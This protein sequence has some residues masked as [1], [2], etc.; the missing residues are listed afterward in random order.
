MD[1]SSAR[2][3]LSLRPAT[4]LA[5]LLAPVF[6]ACASA[7][8]AAPEPASHLGDVTA[9]GWEPADLDE[10]MALLESRDDHAWEDHG[11]PLRVP[12]HPAEKV[13]QG[14]VV[15]LDPGHGGKAD[16]PG[17]KRGPTGV[18]EAEM[19]LRVAKLLR[20]LLEDAGA[21][22]LLTREGETSEAADDRLD[23]TL[24]RR[25]EI[26][27]DAPRANGGVGA[28]LFISLHHNASS[29]PTTNYPSIW[30]HGEADAAE[31]ALDA[32]LA[33]GHRIGAELR[34]SGVGVTSVLMNDR[35][36][37]KSGF[38]VLRH[39]RVPAF[40]V[41][42]SFFSHPDEEQRLRDALYNLREAYAIYLGLVEYAYGGRP[43]QTL[44]TVEITDER[45][46]VTTMLDEGL[47]DWWGADRQ[48]VLSSTMTVTLDGK[49]LDVTYDPATRTLMA[50]GERSREAAEEH[51]LSIHHA[52]LYKH[53]NW[54]QRYRV[55]ISPDDSVDVQP[56]QAPHAAG[57]L[58]GTP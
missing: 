49:R 9:E 33:V 10:A 13:L 24:K 18:R 3:R 14:W 23:D 43:T 28:D 40:L 31:V 57:P 29:K 56:T 42:S 20:R 17:Y 51:A 55:R 5:T 8:R 38:G 35:Q 22:V 15:A 11:R 54:P 45:I 53:H 19:N 50:T 52:N 36:M 26:A 41:E 25:A 37:F 58:P 32:A 46:E 7:P 47:P 30:F 44:P 4:F 1:T 2:T 48:R 27:N 12:R 21:Q 16:S 34:C 6:W 39:A